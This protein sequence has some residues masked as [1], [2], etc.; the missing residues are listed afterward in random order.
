[1]ASVNPLLST[2]KQTLKQVLDEGKLK[3]REAI[4]ETIKRLKKT[5]L[6]ETI[7]KFAEGETIPL[8]GGRFGVRL[9]G[10]L[11]TPLRELHKD[12]DALQESLRRGAELQNKILERLRESRKADPYIRQFQ[13]ESELRS[14]ELNERLKELE[15]KLKRWKELQPEIPPPV[16]GK[17]LEPWRSPR[18]YGYGYGYSPR[19]Q[20]R[21]PPERDYDGQRPVFPD[22]RYKAE[23]GPAKSRLKPKVPREI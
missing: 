12:L 19:G 11:G 9:G 3:G 16:K 1:M 15:E 18:Y 6:A 7:R 14:R 4:K 22:S 17:P 13:K 10:P 8:S 5:P 20:R 23:L 21:S 2:A